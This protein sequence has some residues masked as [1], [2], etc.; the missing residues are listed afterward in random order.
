M[1]LFMLFFA[2]LANG[3]NKSIEGD[4]E[5]ILTEMGQKYIL[6]ISIQPDGT[7]AAVT[8]DGIALDKVTFEN[9]KVYIEGGSPKSTFNGTL[10]EDGLSIE[11]TVKQQEIET[12]AILKRIQKAETVENPQEDN[13]AEYYEKMK[14][15]I[16]QGR[17]F[18][19]QSTATNALLTLISAFHH[20]DQNAL[21]QIFP[22]VKQE[23][24]KSLLSPEVRSRMLVAVKPSIFCKIEMEN[25]QPEESDICAIFTSESPEKEANQLWSFGY[26]EG[27]W[28]FVNSTNA[29]DNWKPQAQQAE[30]LTRTALQTEEIEVNIKS[31]GGSDTEVANTL[32]GHMKFIAWWRLDNN[33]NDSAG[34]LHGSIH[35]NPT[36]EGGKLGQAIHLD[37]DDY[38]DCGNPDALNFGTSDWAI[39]AWFKTTQTGR[40]VGDD[41][42]NRGT[43]F[44]KGGDET[45]GIRYTLAINENDLGMLT[46]TTDDNAHNKV[47]VTGGTRVNDGIWHH[48]VGMRISN[49]LHLYIDGKLNGRSLLYDD[50]DLSGV[51][52]HNAYIGTITDNRDKSLYKYF[53]GTIDEVCVFACALDAN[54]V[55]ALYSGENPTIV[56]EQIKAV[57]K[58]ETQPQQMNVDIEGDWEGTIET[59]NASCILKIRKTAEGA[60]T[61]ILTTGETTIPFN[62]IT[63]T[64][65]KLRFESLPVQIIYEG[66]VNTDGS[67]I[68]GHLQLPGQQMTALA[69]KRAN[70]V[71]SEVE[72]QSDSDL[73]TDPTHQSTTDQSGS[74]GSIVTT[75][76]LILIMVGIIGG[77]VF[78]IMKSSIRR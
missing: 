55:S 56:A 1:I 32:E 63:Y 77:I 71:R 34:D 29:T 5:V 39:S 53:V 46:L 62:K 44:A 68:K 50:Y 38:V 40:N 65:G 67:A 3:D 31:R 78:F 30:A 57:T 9:G 51:S 4:W 19:D 69:L 42:M 8:P 49:Q 74:G 22:L 41:Q 13:I 76:I 33:A 72:P 27:A 6:K 75:L 54:S 15:E 35:G 18:N 47:Q 12:P 43:I 58:P 60:L 24:F 28:R 20:Q 2:T 64:N 52:Q 37:G 16:F 10:K 25:Q 17:S 36:F 59:Q 61:A 14:N 45:D 48:V 7:L 73:M 66:T 70:Q 23:Q 21:E 26:V 11:G